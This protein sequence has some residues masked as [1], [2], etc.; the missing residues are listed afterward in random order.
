MKTL[1]QERS[2]LL[3]ICTENVLYSLGGNKSAILVWHT[4]LF[5]DYLKKPTKDNGSVFATSE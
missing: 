4:I 2:Q 5:L 1:F 3:C